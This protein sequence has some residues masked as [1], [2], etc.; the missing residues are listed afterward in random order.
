MVVD[1]RIRA[2][3]DVFDE[4]H[5]LVMAEPAL[6][7]FVPA[8]STL[9]S[10]ARDVRCG[11]PVEVVVPNDRSIRIP[12]RELAERILAIVDRAPGP[13]GHEDEESIKA[14]A[15]LHSNLARAVVFAI[16]ADYPDLMRH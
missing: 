6:R 11:V 9:S 14:M 7:Q 12:T 8:T 3:A 15:I 13:L 16:I 2:L 4:L 10:L 5:A 1:P